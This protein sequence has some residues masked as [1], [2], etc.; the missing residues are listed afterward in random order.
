MNKNTNFEP[1]IGTVPLKARELE[2][3]TIMESMAMPDLVSDGPDEGPLEKRGA[4]ALAD[5][6]NAPDNCRFCTLGRTDLKSDRLSKRGR[7]MGH[8]QV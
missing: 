1:K 4:E 2:S 6:H 8:K 3:M 7:S 5:H